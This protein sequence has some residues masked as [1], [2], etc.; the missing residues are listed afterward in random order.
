MRLENLNSIEFTT[1]LTHTAADALEWVN[2][3]RFANIAHDGIGRTV[4]GA[5]ATAFTLLGIN[6]VGK[7][8]LALT[9]AALVVLH[10]FH[11]F[12]VEIVDSRQDGVW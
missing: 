9:G 1:R 12:I 6:G 4:A 5:S 7:Q 8:C 3:M 2:D 10:M 11:I